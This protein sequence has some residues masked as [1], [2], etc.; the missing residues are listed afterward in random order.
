M[1]CMKAWTGFPVPYARSDRATSGCLAVTA[2]LEAKFC[3][4]CIDDFEG[5]CSLAA[6]SEG[7]PRDSRNGPLPP[8]RPQ[9]TDGRALGMQRRGMPLFTLS[10]RH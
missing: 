6:S 8:K 2:N 10:S 3:A 5:L 9:C 1:A 4:R 7:G